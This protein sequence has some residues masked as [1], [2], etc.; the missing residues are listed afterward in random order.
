MNNIDK[1]LF[2][3]NSLLIKLIKNNKFFKKKLSVFFS[4]L[5]NLHYFFITLFIDIFNIIYEKKN[6][7]SSNDGDK[8]ILDDELPNVSLHSDNFEITK[9]HN[10]VIENQTLLKHPEEVLNE[11]V[12]EVLN[13]YKEGKNLILNEVFKL[14]NEEINDC[15][16]DYINKNNEEL[17]ENIKVINEE[18]K[19]YVE[20]ETNQQKENIKEYIEEETNEQKEN[21]K[22]NIKEDIKE[23]IK[24][25]IKENIKE[26][27]KD[28]INENNEINE[29]I[30]IDEVDFGD[31]ITSL[32]IPQE[33]PKIEIKNLPIKIKIGKKK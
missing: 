30:S 21:I 11:C 1:T 32:T 18:L 7:Y 5:I 19:E 8:L 12:D 25:D 6:L 4:F 33:E 2:L 20:E 26:E 3:K 15:F 23:N 28:K 13:E 16:K 29:T 31:Y 17:I 10:N 24:E 27:T 9:L 14:T 22:E